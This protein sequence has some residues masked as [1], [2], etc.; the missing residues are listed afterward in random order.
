MLELSTRDYSANSDRV[1]T[2][3]KKMIVCVVAQTQL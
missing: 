1:S 3:K 2:K